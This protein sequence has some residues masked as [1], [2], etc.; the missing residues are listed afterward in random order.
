VVSGWRVQALSQPPAAVVFYVS[1]AGDDA[2]TGRLAA[3]TSAGNDGPVRT[4]E[5]AR[6][7]VRALSPAER[8]AGVTV[9]LRGG[10]Y[11]LDRTFTLGPEDSG[12]PGRPVTYRAY[13]GEPV[14]LS[15][16][17]RVADWEPV[18]EADDPLSARLPAA[19]RAGVMVADISGLGPFER[20]PSLT[21][22]GFDEAPAVELFVHGSR[23]ELARWPN[24]VPDA[25]DGDAWSYIEDLTGPMVKDRFI[26]A[27]PMPVPRGDHHDLLTHIWSEDW[28]DSIEQVAWI[29]S[30]G[31]E[32]VL[33]SPHTYALTRGLRFAL[34]NA[35]ELL[36][37]PGEWY[38]DRRTGRLYVWPTDPASL[39]DGAVISR[40]RT[41]VR[42]EGATNILIENLGV[43]F[44]R[45]A[46]IEALR[47]SGVTIAG[48]TLRNIGGYAIAILGDGATRDTHAVG[49]TIS[50]TGRGG[51]RLNG[52]D[53][54]RLI[55]GGNSAEDNHIHHYGRLINTYQPAVQVGGV[56]N[57]VAHNRIH[58][59][60]HQAIAING[61]DHLIEYNHMRDVVQ[62]SADAGAIYMGRDFS[63]QGHVIRYNYFQDIYGYGLKD[64][65]GR[66]TRASDGR[67]NYHSPHAAWGIYLDDGSSGVT[68][69]G[70]VFERVPMGA[71]F[72]G[73][74]GKDITI[75]NNIMSG[76]APAVLMNVHTCR[77]NIATLK[78]RLESVQY[79]SP[80]YS[81]RYPLLKS[82]FE[83]D[84]CIPRRMQIRRNVVVYEDDNFYGSFVASREPGIASAWELFDFDEVTSTVDGNVVWHRGG[85]VRVKHR[86]YA[87]PQDRASW[88]A[89]QAMGFDRS[90][91]VA[92]P[93][94]TRQSR[95]ML[96]LAPDSP[97]FGLGFERIPVEQI[98]PRR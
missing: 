47:T 53:R 32:I 63:Q 87:R 43:E 36:D 89:W 46:G 33:G 2:S 77:I 83:G 82:Y 48:C 91:I 12:V 30:N 74:G 23:Q 81:E 45:G 72:S 8:A 85:S 3:P 80:P 20:E 37:A 56:G 68:V 62:N 86:L 38:L 98:G 19:A 10:T 18:A 79:A 96:E 17:A 94:L 61:N 39:A 49:N 27:E 24:R 25:R 69:Y 44:V 64:P 13:P 90:S 29:S 92:D 67:W 35:P 50:E 93:R 4:L 26:A 16:G 57:R 15:G 59:A 51:I 73:G 42:I 31:R 95:G 60:P 21:P 7:L 84:P 71:I 75:Q 9:L 58:D 14:I 88:E 6:D 54:A 40:L 34:R 52:G 28:Y 1:P 78:D 97:A 66:A 22:F 5:R 41:A 70:N 65:E 55:A 11:W 76:S